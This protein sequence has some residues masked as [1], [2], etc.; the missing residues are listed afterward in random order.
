MY[1]NCWM[2]VLLSLY[3]V[4]GCDGWTLLQQQ[5]P[6]RT[7][8]TQQRRSVLLPWNIP[9]EN[10]GDEQ[11]SLL[12][13]IVEETWNDAM[14][15]DVHKVT[16]GWMDQDPIEIDLPTT[17]NYLP[18]TETTTTVDDLSTSIWPAGLAGAI[19]CQSMSTVLSNQTVLEL[20]SGVGLMGWVASLYANSTIL[21]DHDHRAVAR[22]QQKQSS[23]SS[24]RTVTA[25]YLEWKDASIA[26]SI[27][28]EE[29]GTA[30]N[31]SIGVVDMILASDIA[32]YW[33]LL[34]PIMDTVQSFLHPHIGTVVIVGGANRQSQWDLYDHM[35]HGCYNPNTDQHEGPWPGRTRMLLFRLQMGEWVCSRSS[36]SSEKRKSSYSSELPIAVIVH[37]RDPD[38]P[39]CGGLQF[40]PL[41]DHEA[42]PQD[43]ESI[44]ISF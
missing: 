19:L 32:Y 9:A 29:H 25:Q 33:Y 5:Y 18:G 42:T 6:H 12:G 7:T 20:G 40:H 36:T 8:T 17:D 37:E 14:S 31:R 30:P 43:R 44:L 28:N 23:T 26:S 27:L 24:S 41:Y 16:I 4:G 21:T 13:W 38:R 3:G 11:P 15:H 1:Y 22:L 2:F 39:S 34:R 35:C 10:A